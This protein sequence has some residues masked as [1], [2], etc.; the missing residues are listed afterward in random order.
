MGIIFILFEWKKN[1][2]DFVISYD[3]SKVCGYI[4]NLVYGGCSRW[5]MDVYLWWEYIFHIFLGSI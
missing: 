2:S 3:F 1:S 4:F 5:L